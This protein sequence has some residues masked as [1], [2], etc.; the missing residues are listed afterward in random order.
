MLCHE[1]TFPT[2]SRNIGG[3]RLFTSA[4]TCTSSLR[5]W[6]MRHTLITLG[7]RS[8][9]EPLSFH[10]HLVVHCPYET[11]TLEQC[12]VSLRTLWRCH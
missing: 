2:L 6:P 4:S 3:L 5:G 8:S 1:A 10:L 7:E 11:R 12:I 9:Q